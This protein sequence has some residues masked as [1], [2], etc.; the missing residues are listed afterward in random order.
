MMVDMLG[1]G[2]LIEMSR[3][4]LSPK[5]VHDCMEF[6]LVCLLNCCFLFL[7]MCLKCFRWKKINLLHTEMHVSSS[8]S[9]V[10]SFH[11]PM[12]KERWDLFLLMAQSNFFLVISATIHVSPAHSRNGKNSW[13]M[14]TRLSCMYQFFQLF[15]SSYGLNVYTVLVIL[16]KAGKTLPQ[17][18]LSIA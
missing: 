10:L 12:R 18:E 8:S 7:A 1:A 2:C 5:S 11:S 16:W 13:K 6:F 15:F 17:T 9:E 3:G 4:P 14:S